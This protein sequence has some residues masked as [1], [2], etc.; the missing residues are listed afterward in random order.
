MATFNGTNIADYLNGTEL[1][2]L[3]YGNSGND[4]N[5]VIPRRHR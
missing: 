1:V 3:I 2:D 4:G 5:D